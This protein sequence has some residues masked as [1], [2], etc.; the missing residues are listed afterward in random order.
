MFLMLSQ[1]VDKFGKVIAHALARCEF[2]DQL[3]E[4]YKE[5]A[6]RDIHIFLAHWRT[7]VNAELRTNSRGYLPHRSSL[8]L[9]DNFPDLQI[10]DKYTYPVNSSR[11]GTSGGGAMRDKGELDLKRLVEFCEEK[12]EWGYRS[13]IIKRFRSL[14]WHAAVIHVLRRAALVADEREKTR[15]IESGIHDL[16]IRSPLKPSQ[17]E[18]VGTPASLVKQHLAGDNSSK[19]SEDRYAAAF[20]NGEQQPRPLLKSDNAEPH[21]LI[22][23]VVGMRHHISTDR[24][25]EYRV[26]VSPVQL[27]SLASASIKGKRA[28]PSAM[29]AASMEDEFNDISHG[30]RPKNGTKKPPPHPDSSMRIWVPGSML[31]Q[32]H[33]GLVED[34]TIGEEARK[35]KKTTKKG[36]AEV[37][38][39]DDHHHSD[40]QQSSLERQHSRRQPDNPAAMEL[41]YQDNSPR[42]DPWF[43]SDGVV[44]PI[45]T[46]EF[47][48]AF[49][50]PE[51]HGNKNPPHDDSENIL[52]DNSVPKDSLPLRSEA[53]FSDRSLGASNKKKRGKN[54]VSDTLAKL[55]KLA[56]GRVTKR[57]KITHV[58]IA[59]VSVGCPSYQP[60]PIMPI[61]N[62]SEE[63]SP[64]SLARPLRQASVPLRRT[65]LHPCVYPEPSSSQ[66]SRLSS[67][68]DD[69][70]DLT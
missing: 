39:D 40:T 68:T 66:E 4:A 16:L 7:A 48:F 13:A 32:V 63:A 3:L 11:A 18:A 70:V 45:S 35:T 27:V 56:S 46:T 19:Y 59:G 61:L 22:I 37:V 1:G 47:L 51:S 43:M 15:R 65:A 55:D 28:E 12:F 38:N 50:D 67:E 41:A 69:F 10:L 44:S 53:G 58:D 9:P 33:P 2:G 49:P 25:L 54:L 8:S 26:E 62:G 31:H 64:N 57:Q 20:V 30:E 52:V 60:F 34:Y 14:I 6:V 5:R 36:T 29:S 42:L 17:A 23:K 24:I 21:P